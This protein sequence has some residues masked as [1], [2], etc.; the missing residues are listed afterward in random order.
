MMLELCLLKDV[1]I[2][3]VLIIIMMYLHKIPVLF[4][5][6]VMRKGR[7]REMVIP[8]HEQLVITKRKEGGRKRVT[9]YFW[10]LNET[11]ST[12]T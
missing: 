11:G 2:L 7:E 4:P 8:M 9:P 5:S 1:Q 10:T 6:L 3:V 12:Q